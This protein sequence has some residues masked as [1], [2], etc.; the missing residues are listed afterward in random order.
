[1][2]IRIRTRREVTFVSP[3]IQLLSSIRGLRSRCID[4][5]ALPRLRAEPDDPGVARRALNLEG[6]EFVRWL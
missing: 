6:V 1:M 4:R 3:E 5:H 2:L